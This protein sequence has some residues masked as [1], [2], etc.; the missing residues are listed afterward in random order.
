MREALGHF[1]LLVLLAL[2]RVGDDAYGVPICRELEDALG[3]NV[4]IAKVYA[5]LDQLQVKRLVISR[6][7][8][9]TAVRGGRAKRH[10]TA[11]AEGL[12]QVRQA[13]SALTTLWRRLPQLR[14]SPA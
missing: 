10:F 2:L 1:E 4:A 6:L 3:R 8:E 13:H 7:G 5:A 14:G 12:R 11:T 9:P